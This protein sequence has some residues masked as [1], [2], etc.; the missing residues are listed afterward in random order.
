MAKNFSDILKELESKPY[1]ELLALT[2]SAFKVVDAEM[3]KLLPNKKPS[4]LIAPL[5]LTT[6]A[7][8]GNFS[9]KENQFLSDLFGEPFNYY[10]YKNLVD[11]HND[12]NLVKALDEFIDACGGEAKASFVIFCA[13]FAAVDGISYKETDYLTKLLA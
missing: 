2:R 4:E 7:I 8:D 6:L 13:C 5:M 3:Q 12:A 9:K 1:E 10:E 11:A